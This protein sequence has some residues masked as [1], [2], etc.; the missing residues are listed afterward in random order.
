MK[1]SRP[2]FGRTPQRIPSRCAVV[3][4]RGHN[5]RAVQAAGAPGKPPTCPLSGKVLSANRAPAL[6]HRGRRDTIYCKDHGGHALISRNV[7]LFQLP[8]PFPESIRTQGNI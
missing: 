8:M 7:P 6:R 1:D 5:N 3:M 4:E 2:A